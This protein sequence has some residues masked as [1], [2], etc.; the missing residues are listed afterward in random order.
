MLTFSMSRLGLVQESKTPSAVDVR[1][2]S[3]DLEEEDRLAVLENIKAVVPDHDA[4]IQGAEVRGRSKEL[5]NMR[6]Q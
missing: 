2:R 3:D 1:K 4:R 6:E 5:I